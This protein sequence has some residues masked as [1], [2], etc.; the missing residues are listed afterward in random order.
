[1]LIKNKIKKEKMYFFILI[2]S[3]LICY[4]YLKIS[5]I[6]YS[7]INIKIKLNN[8]KKMKNMAHFIIQNFPGT[9]FYLFVLSF[10]LVL[11]CNSLLKKF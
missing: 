4:I 1:M 2:T 11:I 9:F 3:K 10:I 6:N 8:I 5:Y 7:K